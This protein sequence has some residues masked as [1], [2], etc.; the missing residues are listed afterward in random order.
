MLA[1]GIP[2]LSSFWVSQMSFCQAVEQGIKASD[3]TVPALSSTEYLSRIQNTRGDAWA[4][5]YDL[6]ERQRF[7]E[8]SNNLVLPP[9]DDIRQFVLYIPSALLKEGKRQEA[10]GSR[11]AYTDYLR[12]LKVL[13]EL[14]QKAIPSDRW[15]RRS[16]S[17]SC[18]DTLACRA[19]RL[20][21]DTSLAGNRKIAGLSL[22]LAGDG[23]L[24]YYAYNWRINPIAGGCYGDPA[25]PLGPENRD[26]M[27]NQPRTLAGRIAGSGVGV[28]ML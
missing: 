8:L 16:C 12:E 7:I 23:F 2:L 21:E 25:R 20:R 27:P 10:V 9:I 1:T 13:D 4:G 22:G 15:C 19:G 18:I 11:R 28:V 3:Y 24:H 6:V 5:L 26:I 14:A 17:G